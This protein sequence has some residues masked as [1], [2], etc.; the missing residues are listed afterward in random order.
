N[1]VSAPIFPVTV[2]SSKDLIGSLSQGLLSALFAFEGWIVVT[3]LANEVK[4]PEN[5]L[6]RAI[7]SGLSIVTL[8]Y[9]LI[10]YTFLTV[11]PINQL[12]N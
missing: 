2:G 7:I 6:S 1:K 5:D 3:N 10:N 8:I 12:V 4:N 9:V 11:L